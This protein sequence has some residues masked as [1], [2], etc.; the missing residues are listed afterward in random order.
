MKK[1]TLILASIIS[2]IST[3][4][5]AEEIPASVLKMAPTFMS[6]GSNAALVAAVNKQNTENLSLDEIKSRDQK[7]QATPGVDAFMTSLLENS[8]AKAL[9]EIEK[10]KP[11]FVELFLMDNKGAN[12]SM[13]NKTG[14]Y[15]QGDEAKWKKSFNN[16][17]GALHVGKVK[18]DESAQAYLVQVSVPVKD[19][20]KVVGALTIGINLDELGE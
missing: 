8:G 7:W 13:T 14:D 19:A 16:G 12:V 11:Y 4:L 3:T 9:F 1:T 10:S 5:L 20:D 15:W 18:F 2:L 17:A 6:F